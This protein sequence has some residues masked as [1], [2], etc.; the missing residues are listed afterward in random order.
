MGRR[1]HE[2]IRP[3]KPPSPRGDELAA[4]YDCTKFDN[5]L[6]RKDI[7]G[8]EGLYAIYRDGRVWSYPR[9]RKTGKFLKPTFNPSYGGKGYLFVEL[10]KRPIR[11]R[12]AIHRLLAK[13]FIP[14]PENRPEVNHKNG[15]TT[16]N[17]VE[18]LEWVTHQENMAHAKI[19]NL[20]NHPKGENHYKHKLT[21]KEVL[22]IREL[23]KKRGQPKKL[24]SFYGMNIHTIYQIKYGIIWKHV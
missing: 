7:E 21:S 14:N 1:E 22:R 2:I 6:N 3:A 13:A 10:R 11:K 15:I 20:I 5:N 4:R 16:D 8:W 18:N 17:R 24:A 9:N 23:S 12:I 19:H